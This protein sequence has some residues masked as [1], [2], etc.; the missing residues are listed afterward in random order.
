MKLLPESKEREGYIPTGLDCGDHDTRAFYMALLERARE[1]AD[2]HN[3]EKAKRKG[4][5]TL[6]TTKRRADAT[7]FRASL[8]DNGD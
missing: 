6:I 5:V 4:S 1:R 8:P 3:A 7:S 2:A